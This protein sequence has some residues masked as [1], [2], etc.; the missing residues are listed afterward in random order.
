M[1]HNPKLNVYIIS[2]KP[3]KQDENKT[4]REFLKEK[5]AKN[6]DT[7][8]KA[9]MIY[10]FTSFING[11][12]QDE[13]HKDDKS[14]KVIGIDD[15]NML[16]M[17]LYSDTWMIDGVIEGGKYGI[18][19]EY[20]DTEKK[21]GKTEI[22]PN[23]AVLD[24]YY[25]LLNPILNDKYAVLLTQSY[26]EE[27]IQG[28]INEFIRELLGGCDNYF[29]VDVEPFVPKRLKEKYDLKSATKPLKVLIAF[30]R[31]LITEFA[32]NLNLKHPLLPTISPYPT[33]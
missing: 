7:S 32:D 23:Y 13:F 28:P 17:T 33:M 27:S 1:A 19:R 3:K 6:S 12:G 30:T 29:K 11:V 14:K 20:Q 25:I 10:L 15:G 16:P 31:P 26:T 5:Y 4:F 24:K 2:L 9:L 22:K 21:E 8:D 18:L